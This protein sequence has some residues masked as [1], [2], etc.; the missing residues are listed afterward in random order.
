MVVLE[1]GR[2]ER[3]QACPAPLASRAVPTLKSFLALS[4]LCT[5]FSS[6]L[7]VAVRGA[8]VHRAECLSASFLINRHRVG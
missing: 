7:F 4:S 8:K 3:R 2:L 5:A 1:R 6:K